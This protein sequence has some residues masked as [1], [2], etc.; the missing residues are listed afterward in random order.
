M[1]ISARASA[2]IASSYLRVRSL[3]VAAL[4]WL[5]RAVRVSERFYP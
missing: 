4:N 5:K 1:R 3:T 2:T